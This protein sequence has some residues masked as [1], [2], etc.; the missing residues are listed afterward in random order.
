[1]RRSSCVR[2]RSNDWAQQLWGKTTEYSGAKYMIGISD[3]SYLLSQVASQLDMQTTR[4]QLKYTCEELSEWLEIGASIDSVRLN[5][6]RYDPS[7]RMCSQAREY[8]V[9]R[10][11]FLS[12]WVER[13]SVFNF[14]WGGLEITTKIVVPT[15]WKPGQST[16]DR[17][18]SY[19]E[20]EFGV[21]SPVYLYREVLGELR[22]SVRVLWKTSSQFVSSD[23][24]ERKR[25]EHSRFKSIYEEFSRY[26]L[27]KL[28]GL[29][30]RVVKCLRNQLAHGD[31]SIPKLSDYRSGKEKLQEIEDARRRTIDLCTRI[32]LLSTQMM[33]L[34]AIEDG[35]S[36]EV[37]LW[38]KQ[39]TRTMQSEK[40]L[41]SVH[42]GPGENE[43]G[44]RLFPP[45]ILDA[46]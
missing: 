34:S 14:I 4:G 40:A 30:V 18:A 2:L 20:R 29:G 46:A 15:S 11:D 26:E 5:T 37:K 24:P 6:G 25:P 21:R 19:L 38:T 43:S 32:L 42:I 36:P 13:F 9:E 31:T 35:S 41:T 7:F 22:S 1:M 10:S 27:D 17:A 16:P 28:S 8:A 39:G 33:L 44:K 45:E 12:E 3:H 23:D